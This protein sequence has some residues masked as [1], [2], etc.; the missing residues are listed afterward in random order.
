M[1]FA[2]NWPWR[3]EAC[4]D[5]FPAICVISFLGHHVRFG[6]EAPLGLTTAMAAKQ[7]VLPTEFVFLAFPEAPGSIRGH[8]AGLPDR[9]ACVHKKSS[10]YS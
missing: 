10:I 2:S 9:L 1:R 3:L 8:C 6:D 4:D 5:H 7:P